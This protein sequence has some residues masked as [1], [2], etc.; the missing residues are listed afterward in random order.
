ME[1]FRKSCSAEQ[2][3]FVLD[4]LFDEPLQSKELPAIDIAGRHR[5]LQL[6]DLRHILFHQK[7]L[8][9][10]RLECRADNSLQKHKI[11]GTDWYFRT[12]T[13]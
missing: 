12:S 4:N 10:N 5:N 7:K 11:L 6:M 13:G 3:K 2:T 8:G 1:L 9:N